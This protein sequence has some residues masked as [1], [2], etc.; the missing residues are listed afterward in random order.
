MSVFRIYPVKSNTIASGLYKNFNSGQNAITDIWYGGGGTDTSPEKRNSYSRF[1]VKF[2]LSDLQ[3]K[4]NNGEIILSNVSSFK[5]KMTNSIPR[6]KVLEPEYE[7]DILDK[8]ISS[9]FDLI[10]FPI[11]KNWDQGRGYDLTKEFAVH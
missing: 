11:N 9:S 7:F 6:D 10:S 5:L 4:I 8:K 3:T 1:L 2:D